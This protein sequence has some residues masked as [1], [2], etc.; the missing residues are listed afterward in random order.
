MPNIDYLVYVNASGVRTVLSGESVSDCWELRGRYGFSAPDVELVTQ[1]YI[2][3]QTK[4]VGRIIKPRTVTVNMIVREDTRAKRDKAFFDMVEALIDVD[5][6]DIGR[7][8]VLRSDY[9]WAYL[10]C[11]YA[12][13]LKV[14]DEYKLFHRFTLE[15]YAE[16]PYFYSEDI[17]ETVELSQTGDYFTLGED[18]TLG[19]WCLDWTTNAS[20]SGVVDNPFN[21]EADPIYR[22]AGFRTDLTISRGSK[23][24]S[25]DGLDMEQVDV[26]VIDTRE[27]YKQAYI[28]HPDGTRTDILGNL[29]WTDADLSLP[30]APGYNTI[31]VESNLGADTNLEVVFTMTALSA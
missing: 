17:I 4:I 15:F 11:A 28:L 22:I 25:F 27:R 6:G 9:T 20:G 18:L 19:N 1:K 31:H 23:S 2:N 10:N 30:L 29:V 16:D 24:L 13:G 26:I 12:S 7:L 8:Y 21:H 14:K 5:G 3:G